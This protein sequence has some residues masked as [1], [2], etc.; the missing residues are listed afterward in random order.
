LLLYQVGRAAEGDRR[1]RDLRRLW[2]DTEHFVVVP[3]PL[4][5]LR[6]SE[7]ETLR[8]I[9]AYVGSDQGFRPMARVPE[10]GNVT[11][12]FRPEEFAVR[13]MRPGMPFRA[14]VSFGHNGPF[15]RPPT[16]GPNR[17]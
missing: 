1:F 8:T 7:S 14:H 6:D 5:W 2:R 12:P 10:F 4:N 13:S 9:Q 17:G 16:A 3:E 11:V 15:L